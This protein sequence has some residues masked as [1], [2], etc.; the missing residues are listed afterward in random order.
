MVVAIDGPSGTG[1]STIAKKIAEKYNIAFLYSGSF[2]RGSTLA[3]LRAGIK[4]DVEKSIL[5]LIN[6]VEFD[7]V[8]EHLVLNGEDVEHLLHS[9]DVDLNA[10]KVSCIPALRSLINEKL[11]SITSKISFVCEGRDMT[12]VVFPNA[13]HKFYL[14]AS[15]DVQAERRFLQRPEGK[16][17]EE[18][19]QDIIKRDEIDRNKAVGALK[20]SKDSQYIDTTYLTID[21]VCAIIENKIYN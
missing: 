1:K 18:I 5:E 2:Y 11:Q 20:I 19:K 17:L 15:V 16:T 3:V 8:N 9:S 4:V 6:N 12:T 13:E 21:E 10:A 7:Y 14:D